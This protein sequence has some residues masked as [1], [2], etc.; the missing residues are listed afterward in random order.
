MTKRIFLG[1]LVISVWCGLLPAASAGD[2]GGKI[3]VVLIDG[4]NNHN[5][6]ATTPVMKKALEESGRFVVDVA[7]A[8][9]RPKTPQ[10]PKAAQ[11]AAKASDNPAELA[12]FKEL[13]ASYKAADKVYRD[14]MAQFTIPLEKYQVV[15]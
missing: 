11:G 10:K 6:R 7:T 9:E 15:V 2:K 12:K 8:P 1:L 14:K 5:W 3:R 4:Q 13:E